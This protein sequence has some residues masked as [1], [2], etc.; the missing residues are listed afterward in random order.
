MMRLPVFPD[1]PC[2]LRVIY[3][4]SNS[5]KF[6]AAALTESLITTSR[7]YLCMLSFN[8]S[9]EGFRASMVLRTDLSMFASTIIALF[10]RVRTQQT[11]TRWLQIAFRF[12]R[13]AKFCRA[14][15]CNHVH[16]IASIRKRCF[17]EKSLR[18]SML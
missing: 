2:L 18:M 5:S 14:F 8:A 15:A 12:E 3:S 10:Q 13:Q 17:D 7:N 6:H 1:F 11:P 9:M 16:S 4:T